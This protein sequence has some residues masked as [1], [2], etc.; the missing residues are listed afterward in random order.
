MAQR[1]PEVNSVSI[2]LVGT[3]NPSIFQPQW[4]VRQNL[5]PQ[6][7][8]NKADVKIIAPQV[9]QFETERFVIQVT[10]NRFSATSKPD[11]NPSLTCTPKISPAEM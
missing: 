3:F 2:V 4:F 6:E 8:G 7:E 1:I 11:A 10:A 5:L 9:C